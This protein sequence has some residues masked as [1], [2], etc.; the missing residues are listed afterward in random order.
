MQSADSCPSGLRP[1]SLSGRTERSGVSDGSGQK[2][3]GHSG[4]PQRNR[5][6]NQYP[7]QAQTDRSTKS[8]VPQQAPQF[9][10]S[11][12]SSVATQRGAPS[13]GA[14]SAGTRTEN[15]RPSGATQR[16]IK[17][18]KT[19]KPAKPVQSNQASSPTGTD[20][21]PSMSSILESRV[22]H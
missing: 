16:N 7:S 18:N 20:R 21:P 8:N 4:A 17:D 2:T 15:E 11:P 10:F 9:V 13:N 12:F 22:S 1:T 5:K 19:I 3:N 14:S 6:E